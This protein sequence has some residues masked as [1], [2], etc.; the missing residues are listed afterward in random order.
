MK[1]AIK[2]T[3]VFGVV[4]EL[5]REQTTTTLWADLWLMCLWT[6]L[7]SQHKESATFSDHNTFFCPLFLQ[8][9]TLPGA[10]VLCKH[11]LRYGSSHQRQWQ[12]TAEHVQRRGN[13]FSHWQ[14]CVCILWSHTNIHTH[15]HTHKCMRAHSL[16]MNLLNRR[17]YRRHKSLA[18]TK[19]WMIKIKDKINSLFPK[20]V[21]KCNN[22]SESRMLIVLKTRSQQICNHVCKNVQ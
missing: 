21:L 15:T 17:S 20:L 2:A 13:R 7:P 8:T 10:H 16:V 22:N 11:R 18:G 12:R 4:E 5:Q 9:C 3:P 19:E 6:D 1:V 14:Q